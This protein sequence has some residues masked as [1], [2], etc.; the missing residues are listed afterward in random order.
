MAQAKVKD[1]EGDSGLGF[2]E[3]LTPRLRESLI[4]GQVLLAVLF[5]ASLYS[6]DPTDPGWTYT[7]Q[8]SEISNLVGATGAWV[9]DVLL[10]LFGISAFVFPV[11]LLIP[12][13]R[14]LANRDANGFVPALIL[15]QAVGLLLTVAACAVLADLH[16]YA[17]GTVLREG[18]GGVLGQLLSQA[19]LPM[20]SY[21]GTTVLMLALLL[22]GLTLMIEISWLNVIDRTG[23]WAVAFWVGSH[24]RFRNFKLQRANAGAV[25]GNTK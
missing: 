24:Q 22:L 15:V 23:G 12:V 6:F 10:V 17:L 20:V 11:I 14:R 4:I 13:V 8:D 1:Q 18:S 2:L 5:A 21:V 7:G 16:F 25:E 9:A 3:V 19:L